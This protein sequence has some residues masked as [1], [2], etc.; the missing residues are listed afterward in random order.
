MTIHINEFD[1][2]ND[3]M[4]CVCAVWVM[5]PVLSLNLSK[6]FA[7]LIAITRAMVDNGRA[8]DDCIALLWSL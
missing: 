4:M 8:V 1:G 2:Q 3:Q 5:S 7:V 6:T